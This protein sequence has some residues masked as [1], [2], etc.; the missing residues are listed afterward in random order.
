MDPIE[1]ISGV[2]KRLNNLGIACSPDAAE[3]SPE[4]STAV[5]EFQGMH[6]LPKTGSLDARTKSALQ[7]A[8]GG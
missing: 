8:Y 7:D 4:F 5:R 6:G 3:G 2:C 1:E